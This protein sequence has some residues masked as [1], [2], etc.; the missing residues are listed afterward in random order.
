MSRNNKSKVLI[1]DSLVDVSDLKVIAEAKIENMNLNQLLTEVES[2]HYVRNYSNQKVKDEL[3]K[4]YN[5]YVAEASELQKKI[6]NYKS[7]IQAGTMINANYDNYIKCM[8]RKV[9]VDYQ[10]EVYDGF[11]NHGVE[12]SDFE[13]KLSNVVSELRSIT[14]ELTKVQ[15]ATYQDESNTIYFAKNSIVATTGSISTIVVIAMSI[16]FGLL[17]A[18]I[19]NIVLGYKKYKDEKKCQKATENSENE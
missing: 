16:V 15:K 12:S 11:L 19:V 10:V 5:N 14:E 13:K 1:D 17:V 7:M 8:D 2:N 3:T 18:S 9:V 4:T 6:D